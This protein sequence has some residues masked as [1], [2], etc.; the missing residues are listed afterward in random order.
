M[1]LRLLSAL[2][3]LAGFASLPA[4][5]TK[6][7]PNV[8]F[9]LTDDQGWGDAKFAGHPYVKTPNLDRLVKEGTWF[10]QFYVAATVC[11]P[12]RTAFMTGRTPARFGIHGHFATHDQ[13][14]ARSMP[15]WLDADVTTLPDL[16]RKAG[17]ATAHFGKWHLGN[18]DGAPAPEAYGIDVSK[19]VNSNGPSLGDEGKEPYFRAKST[20]LMVDETIRFARSNKDRP[21]YV[22]LWTLVPHALLK[23]TPEQLAVYAD[24][25]PDANDPAFAGWTRDY[26]GKA[27]DLRSQ[28]QVF[29]ASLTD[30]DTQVGRLLDALDELGLT[31]DT[32]IFFSSDNG[33]E[34]YRINNAANAGVGSAGPLRARKRSMHEGGTR[35][36]GLVRWPGKVPAGRV[37]ESAV[38][39]GVDFLPTVAAL[40]GVEVP[41]G[42]GLEGEDLSALWK[43]AP[44]SPRRTS[45]HWEWISG[46]QGPEDGYM[47]P[48]VCVRDGDWKLF[49][50]HAGG[51]AQLYNIPKDPGERQDVA[52]AN[53]EVVKSLTEKALAWVKSLPPSPAR[54]KFVQSGTPSKTGKKT[55]TKPKK[56]LDRPAIFTSWDKDKDGFLSKDEFIPHMADQADAPARFVRFDQDKDGRLSKEEFVKAGG[57]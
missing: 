13:N 21:F 28:M 19:T 33:P 34:D 55:S 51:A 32:L 22:N 46:V 37:E 41:A 57:K 56:Q 50:N 54:D 52:T 6:R 12:S 2:L 36:F 8:I 40:A 29:C 44:A 31:N 4:A 7:P 10:R 43:G 15:D 14:A 20:A 16:L 23:P 47:P 48:P 35:T 45:L 27:K 30:L 1:S 5:E 26:Y 49:I 11:S 18:G 39:G 17:Y 38:V 3:A 53:P 42:L 9:I 24:L 25:K